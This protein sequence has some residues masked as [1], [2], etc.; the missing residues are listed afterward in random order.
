M[1]IKEKKKFFKKR[2]GNSYSGAMHPN[3]PTRRPVY[4]EALP[5]PVNFVSPKSATCTKKNLE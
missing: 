1:N 3:V 4:S 5:Y 2:L